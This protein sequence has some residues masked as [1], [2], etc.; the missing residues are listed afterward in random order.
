MTLICIELVAGRLTAEQ[1]PMAIEHVTS[2]IRSLGVD[3][4]G[5]K[6]W[7]AV[8]QQ[9]SIDELQANAPSDTDG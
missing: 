2:A 4:Q 5:R 7:I 6:R 8:P 1:R 3:A 9:W